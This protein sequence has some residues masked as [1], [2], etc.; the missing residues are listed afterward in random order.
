[1]KTLLILLIALSIISC[2]EKKE[3]IDYAI[4]SGKIENLTNGKLSITNDQKSIK[5]IDIHKDGTFN[6]T[7]KNIDKGYYTFKYNN[8]TSTFYLEPGYHLNLLLDTKQFD[9]SVKYSG[10]GSIENNYLA[11]KFLNEEKTGKV[12][13]FPY[14]GG[15]DEKQYVHVVD[16]T[17]QL[18][19]NFLKEQKDISQN[20]KT[21]EKASIVYGSALKLNQF[22]QLKQ[23][24]SK[25]KDFK[26]SDKFPDFES[27]LNLEDENLM[28]EKNYRQYLSSHYSDI[29]TKK[30][31]K[32][33][34]DFATAYIKTVA[35]EV[36][37]PKIK[38]FLLFQ[39][40]NETISYTKNLQ[41]F[42][43][44]FMANS[45]SEDH[46][47]IITE[48]YNKLIKLSKGQPSPKFVDYENYKGGTLSLDDL[49]G[50]F[51]YVDVWATWCG[52]CKGQIPFLKKIEKEYHD[53][54]IVF[55]SMSIDKKDDHEKWKKMVKEKSLTGIQLFAPNDWKSDFVTNY[56]IRGIPRFILIDKEGNIVDSNAPRPSSPDLK[57]LFDELKI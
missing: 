29:A 56:G 10:K 52:P 46:K 41:K 50:K 38:E 57:K 15:L 45:S 9:E 48:K 11:Q 28:Q 55:I 13:T 24:F 1:M 8:E 17:K 53:K 54:N 47:K 32:D 49:K 35:D 12:I 4:F 3:P 26:K 39:I 34:T 44:L 31:K 7:L 21:L 23:Y 33:G 43:E 16:S 22:E 20:L 40:A 27:E 18:S 36:K 5:E 6:D 42:Y 14:L 30:S 2:Q 51:V 37:S 25:N 19:L